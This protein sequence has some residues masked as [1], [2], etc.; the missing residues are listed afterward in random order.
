MVGVA[1]L[2][3]HRVVAPVAEG[4][5]PFT[6]PIPLLHAP[7]AQ[8][9][10]APDF[11]SVGRRF[12]SCRAYHVKTKS[13]LTFGCP[14][15]CVKIGDCARICA[16]LRFQVGVLTMSRATNL[17]RDIFVHFDSMI[18]PPRN[19]QSTGFYRSWAHPILGDKRVCGP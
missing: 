3:E 13:Y 9:D 8:P 1:Q 2:V 10:R 15:F 18:I 5:S 14:F 7:V 16:Q 6:H 19:G 12:E 11:E 4:S 17:K